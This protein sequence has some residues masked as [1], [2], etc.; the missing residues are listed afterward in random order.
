MQTLR[1]HVARVLPR[2]A[3][4]CQVN[5]PLL[6]SGCLLQPWLSQYARVSILNMPVISRAEVSGEQLPCSVFVDTTHQCS[7][8]RRASCKLA[9]SSSALDS[10]HAHELVRLRLIDV[11]SQREDDWRYPYARPVVSINR[12]QFLLL[13]EPMR[14]ASIPIN[15]FLH[16][17]QATLIMKRRLHR[18]LL[19]FVFISLEVRIHTHVGCLL[20]ACKQCY[21]SHRHIFTHCA[22][23]QWLSTKLRAQVRFHAH[24]HMFVSMDEGTWVYIYLH[25]CM[26]ICLYNIHVYIYTYFYVHTYV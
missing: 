13:T 25:R 11:A 9:C 15:L 22:A 3:I 26:Y 20:H 16:P 21:S 7:A 23:P 4:R 2:W 10:L 1:D 17:L 18:Q 5:R 8:L 19:H 6:A 24:I 12:D 14:N